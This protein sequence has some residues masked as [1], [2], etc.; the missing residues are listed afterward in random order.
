M[1]KT[2][3]IDGRKARLT[4][5]IDEEAKAFESQL[6]ARARTRPYEDEKQL[7]VE[8]LL[9]QRATWLKHFAGEFRLLQ[10]WGTDGQPVAQATA[11]VHRPRRMKLFSHAI[12]NSYGN[13]FVSLDDQ[14]WTLKHFPK[15]LLETDGIMR[16][17]VHAYRTE[18]TDL[19]DFEQ[20]ARRAGYRLAEPMAV[21][22]TLVYDLSPGPDQLLADLDK[23][24]RAKVRHNSR[25]EVDI[26]VVTDQAAIPAMQAALQASFSRTRGGTAHF[27]FETFFRLAKESASEVLIFGMYLKE[28]PDELLAYSIDVRHGTL[29][30]AIS[31]GSL[32]DAKLRKTP[33]NYF[34][35]WDKVQWACEN[36]ASLLELGGVTDESGS[37]PLAGISS[38]KRHF[39]R[40]QIEVGREVVVTT[41]PLRWV[42][43]RALNVLKR[44]GLQ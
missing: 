30:E 35:L 33:F 38:F 23:K 41:G 19:L 9:F 2:F 6:R 31:S 1:V 15:I 4:D 20:L 14:F 12:V 25:A 5:R 27:D 32:P 8:V 13:S 42:L 16:F 28:R 29:V 26:R 34:L 44:R 11:L 40:N 17:R 21:T 22:R 3:E 36:G 43:F 37:D 7:P 18:H 10:V 24:T 39:T